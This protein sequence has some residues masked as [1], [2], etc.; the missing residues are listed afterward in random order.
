M[1]TRLDAGTPVNDQPMNQRVRTIFRSLGALFL[2]FAQSSIAQAEK[3]KIIFIS[4]KPSHGPMA[5]EHRAGN[6][7][8]AKALNE[9]GLGV[10]AA[11]LP[12]VGYPVDASA[13][14]SAATIVVF[15]TGHQG[16]LLNPKLA[17]FD[18][19]M[20]KGTGV[21]MI[22]WATEAKMGQPAKMF[23][24]WMGGYCALD[25]S[26]NPH[27]TPEFK[28]FPDHPVAN[29]LTP[30]SINDEWYYHM[31][32]V[33]K[34]EG[35]TPIL[36]AVP[37]AE[38]L[39]RPD[40]LRSGNP[41]VRKAV[42]NGESQH[43]AWAYERP[44]GGGRGFGFT[45]AHNHLSWQNDNFR[46]VVLNAILWTAQVEVPED[47]VPSKTPSDEEMRKNLDDKG[48]KKKKPEPKKEVKVTPRIQE[49]DEVREQHVQKMDT[50]ASLALLVTALAN[51]ENPS[52]RTALLNGILKGLEGQR[53]VS[54]PA[55]WQAVSATLSQSP[56]DE[57]SSLTEQLS[58]VFGDEEATQNAL[59]T[60][61]DKD[62]ELDERRRSLA[63]LLVQQHDELL[64]ILGELLDEK[65]L[66]IEAVRGYSAFESKAAPG[67]LLDRYP[68]FE[69]DARR[70]ILE[71][72]ATRKSYATALFEALESKAV[73]AD[74]LPAYVARSLSHLLGESF[75]EKYGVVKLSK[76]KEAIIAQYRKLA[77]PD[78][79]AEAN[80]SKGR[81][82][83]QQV[84]MA[85]HKMYGEGGIIG[86]DITGSNRADL[87]YLLLNIFDPSGDIPDAYQMV[88]ITTKSG[89]LL[90]GTVT[91]EDDQKVV[92][93]M[94]GQQSVV[95]KS[96]IQSRETVPVSMMPDGLLQTL[97]K[98]QALNL[99]KYL[100]TK[101]QVDLPK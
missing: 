72:L 61:A 49:L 3:A 81:R 87:D 58:Q 35:V 98:Q 96:N 2:L 15:C 74:D 16:H 5:H 54:P 65:E 46:K 76:D 6:M 63:S 70:A 48:K 99:F 28:T 20:K 24:Q 38:T 100:Q 7:I 4:G 31:R 42:A 51:T 29:G 32:F 23:L 47:G 43:V 60:L 95:A 13:L 27:W 56:N 26:V 14:D 30:F 62:S 10:D 86:P 33:S 37:G 25:W 57:V 9:S 92:L 68:G 52:T 71:T 82:V 93:N 85:C 66:R 91:G 67:I 40:G 80:A 64:P 19:L 84:C 11:V 89:Q 101:E 83:F 41:D 50:G 73:S 75:T 17:E 12:D 97:E 22:H 34:L 21:V 90:A 44:E 36:S 53:E 39:K 77:T 78:A 55:E 59:D 1:N 88:M 94:I 69:P 8:L 79:L 45:G 18:A